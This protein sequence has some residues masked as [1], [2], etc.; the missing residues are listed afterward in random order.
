MSQELRRL[1]GAN[2]TL[3]VYDDRAVIQPRKIVS[4]IEQDKVFFFSNLLSLEYKRPGMTGGFIKFVTPGSDSPTKTAITNTAKLVDDPNTFVFNSFTTSGDEGD[5]IYNLILK[6]L[7]DR[8]NSIA[9]GSQQAS[10]VADELM[11]LKSLLDDGILN[12]KEFD[13]QK[14]KLLNS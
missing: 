3:V 14:K 4:H 8:Q 2:G 7:N 1:K 11:K 13:D 10:S 9:L 5:E 12:Q 6:N